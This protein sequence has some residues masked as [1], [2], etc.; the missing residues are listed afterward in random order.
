MSLA[1][2][3]NLTVAA[4]QI[5]YLDKYDDALPIGHLS[6]YVN[7]TLAKYADQ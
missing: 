6:L 7:D 3:H 4:C 1:Q 5:L 2:R